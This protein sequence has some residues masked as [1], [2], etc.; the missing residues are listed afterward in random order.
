MNLTPETVIK[1]KV[2][3]VEPHEAVRKSRI[4]NAKQ[5]EKLGGIPYCTINNKKQT[6]NNCVLPENQT[7]QTDEPQTNN[8]EE[9]DNRNIRTIFK[10]PQTNRIIR[11]YKPN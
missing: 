11:N 10:K 3:L 1:T 9:L 8:N 6:S 4:P 2:S 7:N 5:T